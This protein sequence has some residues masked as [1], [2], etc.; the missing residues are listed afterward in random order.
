[1]AKIRLD[2]VDY[3]APEQLAQAIAA[4]QQKHAQQVEA[5]EAEV[6]TRT[7]AV[8]AKDT[9]LGA[10]TKELE[11]VT[12]RADAAEAET[13]K[14]QAELVEARKPE[15]IAKAV[16]ERVSLEREAASVLGSEV[17][18]DA[19]DEQAIKRAV[20]AEVYPDT[21]E[22]LDGKSADYIEALY[23]RA[24]MASDNASQERTDRAE[25]ERALGQGGETRTDAKVAATE[26]HKKQSEAWK[27]PLAASKGA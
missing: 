10:K 14:A 12:A 27:Q 8:E 17:K 5:L 2:G 1:M 9:E 25:V 19:M 18:L 22:R 3:D 21:K 16:Q 20:I 23:E 24:V 15:T 7:D 4:N 26:A 13:K 6:K 11:Q